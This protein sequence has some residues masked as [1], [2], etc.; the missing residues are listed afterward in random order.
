M[1]YRHYILTI[2]ISI[3]IS[4]TGCET[5]VAYRGKLPD[6]DQLAKIKPGQQDK[7]E[8]L[9]LIGSPSSM[10]TFNDN[11]WIYDYKVLESKSFF[12]PREVVHRLY[13]IHFDAHDKVR[14]IR[15]ENGHGR[16]IRPVQH[17]T[18][19]PGDDRTFL[20]TIFGNF[21]RR[22]QKSENE[23]KSKGN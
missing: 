19:S 4:L 22:V 6:P 10:D 3:L 16:N 21:G 15:T 18:K 1:M 14:E 7:E 8:V 23:D 12:T 17:V 11:V 20:Q 2:L 9:R 5:H 13:L